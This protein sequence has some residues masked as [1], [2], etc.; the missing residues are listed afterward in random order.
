MN[1]TLL[2]LVN[3]NNKTLARN[4][5]KS[6]E[7]NPSE[8]VNPKENHKLSIIGLNK[9]IRKQKTEINFHSDETIS[10][11]ID[12]ENP[13]LSI[14]NARNARIRNK[15]GK[16]TSNTENPTG[17][18]FHTTNVFSHEG[19]DVL[20]ESLLKSHTISHRTKETSDINIEGTARMST[21]ADSSIASIKPQSL[22][23]ISIAISKEI[24]QIPKYPNKTIIKSKYPDFVSFGSE[25]KAPFYAKENDGTHKGSLSE[26]VFSIENVFQ[27]YSDDTV[28]NKLFSTTRKTFAPS[29]INLNLDRN[30]KIDVTKTK[31]ESMEVVS[32][33]SEEMA[34]TNTHQGNHIPYWSS[35]EKSVLNNTMD[36]G[37][38]D[39]TISMTKIPMP[40]N[41]KRTTIQS[42]EIIRFSSEER[43]HT[44]NGN[45]TKYWSS[46]E[47]GVNIEGSDER[48]SHENN[49]KQLTSSNKTNNEFNLEK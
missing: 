4:K 24:N 38:T 13:K 45:D 28:E 25:E 43:A 47:K 20:M 7:I 9:E 32:F 6:K 39:V 3:I 17:R 36:E 15:N 46:M 29:K 10:T 5:S 42:T 11:D 19:T 8:Q 49:I 34:P 33:S 1:E 48:D 41:L 27:M 40:I 35:T 2:S 21:K 31:I 12:V 26:N 44:K 37:T 16:E 30:P 23:I 18:E 22:E 14:S